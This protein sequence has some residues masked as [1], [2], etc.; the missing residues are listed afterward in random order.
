MQA[1]MLVIRFRRF[2][3]Y[4]CPVLSFVQTAQEARSLLGDHNILGDPLH[5][6]THTHLPDLAVI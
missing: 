1:C 2:W 4:T 5:L 3:R 6:L